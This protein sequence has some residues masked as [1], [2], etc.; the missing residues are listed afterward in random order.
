MVFSICPLKLL[1]ITSNKSFTLC[2]KWK[3]PVNQGPIKRST[4]S[5]PGFRTRNPM[6]TSGR[7]EEL[8]PENCL[9]P[10]LHIVAMVGKHHWKYVSDSVQTTFDTGQHFDYNI[11]SF[12]ST[13]INCSVFSSCN[14][15]SDH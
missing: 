4:V 2:L 3:S 15:D 14:D 13:V 10:G 12:T 6:S 8:C 7:R 11:A 9:K 5:A 1:G